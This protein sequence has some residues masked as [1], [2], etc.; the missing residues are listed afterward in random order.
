VP[1]RFN[2]FHFENLQK[3]RLN[4]QTPLHIWCG[5]GFYGAYKGNR[6]VLV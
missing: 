6:V 1:T 4:Q 3:N 2:G 5:V